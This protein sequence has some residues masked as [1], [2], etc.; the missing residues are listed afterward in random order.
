M[1]NGMFE[2]VPEYHYYVIITQLLEVSGNDVD[3]QETKMTVVQSKTIKQ[4][5][6]AS[7]KCPIRQQH[8]IVF[9]EP[10]S[11]NKYSISIYCILIMLYY[12]YILITLTVHV[13][14]LGLFTSELQ[15]RRLSFLKTVHFNRPNAFPNPIP[16]SIPNPIPDPFL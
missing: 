1:S 16:K 14:P 7:L 8:Q 4:V 12:I 11:I 2:N 5:V 3:K 10:S 9:E 6:T 15:D 13:D